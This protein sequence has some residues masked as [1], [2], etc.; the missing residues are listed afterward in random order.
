MRD[1]VIIGSGPAGLSAAVYAKRAALDVVVI[2][3]EPFSGGQIVNTK[4][5]DNYLGMKGISGFDLATK[6]KEHATELGACFLEGNVSKIDA[7]KDKIKVE[8]SNGEVIE[9]KN[10]I[11][12]TGAIHKK[13]GAENEEKLTGSG[14]SYCATCDGAFFKGKDVAVI[15]GGDVAL[16]DA[17]YLSNICSKVY[18]INRREALRAAKSVQEA[19]FARDNITFLPNYTVERIEG[20]FKVEKA[21]LKHTINGEGKEID[22]NGIFIAIGMEP[23]TDFLKGVVSIDDNGYIIASEDCRTDVKGIYV[24]GD[25]RTKRLRQ[26]VTA[27]ADGA[28]AVYSLEED[29]KLYMV[30]VTEE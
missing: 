18:L 14:V 25:V 20:K 6:Y 9:T 19:V 16:E 28:N 4:E 8:L 17:L 30:Q 26:L 10:V 1:V 29:D 5:V 22:I 27:V 15:G 21:Y 24:A 23:V 12:A 2:E 3:K 11:I 7:L 13:I